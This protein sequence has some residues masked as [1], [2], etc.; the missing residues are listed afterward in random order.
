MWWTVAFASPVVGVV[1]AAGP[2]D[3]APR[4]E[5]PADRFDGWLYA[6]QVVA[7]GFV[8]ARTRQGFRAPAHGR[9]VE[10][11]PG[12]LVLEHLF[13]E[14][15]HKRRVRSVFPLVSDLAPGTEVQRGEALGEGRGAWSLRDAS[16]ADP[17]ATPVPVEDLD[18]DRF[19]LG[20]ET[21]FVP[22]D[23][24]TLAIVSH[25]DYAL[26]IYGDDGRAVY[27]VS[28]GQAKGEKAQRGDNRT[29][30]GMYF[31]VEKS[32]G[33][34]TGAVGPYY[35]GFWTKLNYPNRYDA[36]RGVE[37]GWIDAAT[38]REIRREWAQRQM[39]PQRTRLGSG[40]GFHGWAYEWSNDSWRHLSW[41]CIVTH[42]ADAGA[43]FEALPM[44]T[45]VV[46]L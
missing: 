31:V 39:T 3:P 44:G 5:F 35:G 11:D 38:A 28:F 37:E 13:Y 30:K 29:P 8:S 1:D 27:D 4:H 41:G 14:D 45:M 7:D 43:I 36:D 42:V 21:L 12:T 33:P 9:V 19:H 34:F 25:D 22:Q 18:P 20:R 23:E 15:H 24:G 46:L 16:D 40:I 6:D 2:H 32:T 10:G 26:R 17:A